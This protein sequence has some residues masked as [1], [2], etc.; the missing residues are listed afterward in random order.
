MRSTNNYRP[1]YAIA[2]CFALPILLA[3]LLFYTEYAQ[4]YHNP[5]GTLITPRVFIKPQSPLKKTWKIAY[6]DSKHEQHNTLRQQTIAKRYQAL[7]KD[8]HRVELLTLTNQPS[9][10]QPWPI[11]AINDP[12][13]HQL[14][15]LRNND[16]ASC[17]YFIIDPQQQ[18]VL[19]YSE[20]TPP[21]AI[22]Q[23]LRKLLKHSPR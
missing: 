21:K 6:L 2:A 12:S 13:Y 20:Q 17:R 10:K 3:Y 5:N 23:D 4:H 19:C 15:Q 11:Y 16:H 8:K 14:T 1:L 7:G 22:D 18:V 9:T